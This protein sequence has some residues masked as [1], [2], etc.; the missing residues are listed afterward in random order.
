MSQ[1]FSAA[2]YNVLASAYVHRGWYPRSPAMV[3]NPA[4]R[5]PA[6]VQHISNLG[7]D[8]LCLQEVEPETFAALRAS[9]GERGYGAEYARKRAGQ[10]DGL[11][12]FYRHQNFQLLS[13]RVLAFA[14]GDG[15]ADSGYA[16]LLVYLQHA[17]GILGVM[18]THLVWDSPG[19]LRQAQRGLRQARELAAEFVSAQ[20]DARGWIVAGDFNATPESEVVSLFDQAGLRCAHAGLPGISTCNVN[21][22]ARMIDY[23]FYSSKLTADPA[24]PER[25]DNRSIL[26]STEQPSDHLALSAKFSWID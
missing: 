9:L 8:I 15:A 11:A 3:L 19:T 4:W 7:A 21:S 10:P 6:L 2:T 17:G 25:I 12:I 26:P 18:D 5:V 14:D 16:A 23:L 22:D 20:A 24:L 1:S 13:A